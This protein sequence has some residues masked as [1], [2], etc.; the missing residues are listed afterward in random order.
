MSHMMKLWER[1]IEYRLRMVNMVSEKQFGF[2]PVKSTMEAIYLLRRMV[3]KHRANKKDLH[4]VFIN[5]EMAYDRVP[6]NII[7]WVLE[8]KG[9]TKGYIEVIRDMYEG[10]ATTIRSPV[11]E[12]SEFSITVELY[13]GSALSPY[14]FALVMDE[15][16]R[17][18]QEDI[19]WCM[20]FADD[21]VLVDETEFEGRIGAQKVD[22]V[23]TTGAAGDA[24]VAGLLNSLASH[25][26]LY[27]DEIAF[28]REEIEQLNTQIARLIST[29]HS[30]RQVV[31]NLQDFCFDHLDNKDDP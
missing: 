17:N 6:K 13:Q 21:I 19:S 16:T 15:L 9:V 25:S 28:Y 26:T 23:D 8:R 12:M 7:W 4:M 11:G 24:F 14:L 10:A 20:I 29:I 22:A 27:K 18:F 1:V 31:T 3:E 2:I 5:L 30:L